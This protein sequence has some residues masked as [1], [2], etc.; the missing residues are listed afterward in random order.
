MDLLLRQNHHINLMH[1]VWYAPNEFCDRIKDYTAFLLLFTTHQTHWLERKQHIRF[2]LDQPHELMSAMYKVEPN[3]NPYTDGVKAYFTQT[4]KPQELE[5]SQLQMPIHQIAEIRNGKCLLCDLK[6]PRLQ[7]VLGRRKE[8]FLPLRHAPL[9]HPR[10][11][12][13]PHMLDNDAHRAN[14]NSDE[15]L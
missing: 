4:R 7:Q 15:S 1:E 10:N 2:L 14:S 11:V 3:Q 6:G 8:E 12:M 5:I 13:G 9:P